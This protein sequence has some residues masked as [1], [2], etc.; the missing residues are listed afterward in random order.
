[1]IA[2]SFARTPLG[3]ILHGSRSGSTI[4]TRHQE[5]LGTSRYAV[6]E[7]NGLG[8]SATI[9]DDELSLHMTNR[10]WGWNARGASDNFLAVEF[11]QPGMTWAISDGQVN[12]FV[13]FLL[14]AR[15]TWP[16]LPSYFPTHAELDGTPVYGGTLDGK[17]DV[18]PKG[19]ARTDVL[20]E[21]I[22]RRLAQYG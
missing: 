20:R 11:A 19:D 16:A 3:I 4:N 18:F 7:P 10:Q 2:G 12:A 5:F 21:R 13:W 22:A 14:E 8:W 1:V 9:G 17:T 15:R 6:N